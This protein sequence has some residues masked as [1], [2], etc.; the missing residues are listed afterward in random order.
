MPMP[1]SDL[2]PERVREL[3]A[4]LG[5]DLSRD[6]AERYA[7][8]IAADLAGYAA[9]D[10]L[11]RD[12]DRDRAPADVTVDP[13]PDEDPHNAYLATFE[14][15][16]GSGP[17]ADLDV[18]LKDNVAVAGV[19]LTCGSRVF[20]HATPG[21][22]ATVVRRLLDAGATL[23][24]KTNMDELA[25]APTGE[26]SQFGSTSNPADPDHVAGGS[27]SGSGAAVGAGD[28]DAAL[29]TDTGGSVRIPASFCGVV[30]FKPSYGVVP[31]TGVVDLSYSL[32]HVGV[33]A[34]DVETAARTVDAMA[35]PDYRDQPSANAR[36][37]DLPTAPALD[38]VALDEVSLGMPRELCGD[39][40][41]DAVRSHV[42]DV[43]DDLSDR[44]V[45]VDPVS[46]PT[47]EDAVAVWN[48]VVNVELASSLLASG[49]PV[50]RRQSVDPTWYDAAADAVA[51][52]GH[53]FGEK[54][55]ETTIVGAHLLDRYGGRHYTR[56]QAV[57]DRLRAEVD[58]A[59][60]G[61]DALVSPT[62]PT[63]APA[64]GE[65]R[66]ADRPVPLA[67]NTRPADLAHVP[68]VSLPCGTVDDLPVGLQLYG[69]RY[70]DG[71]LLGVASA[72]ADRL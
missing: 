61:R 45:D 5:G 10:D 23:V 4:Q 8:R 2:S 31:R 17:L 50:A 44:G 51:A 39:H 65:H 14:M 70:Q 46:L 13:G 49:V 11:W 30:G 54:V 19:P 42:E 53:A 58:D 68:A 22:H 15:G 36:R 9:L 28:V 12:V 34:R 52:R 3:A 59:L 67:F 47:V 16:D 29:G 55:R 26:T 32:D 60:D 21:R 71:H 35:G 62:M 24:G 33:L 25:Y 66:R 20:E 48:A 40:V 63:T 37:V 72:V 56:A 43:V 1:L 27:S 57:R 64:L 18:A 41:D 38:D 6:E 7:D 69:G